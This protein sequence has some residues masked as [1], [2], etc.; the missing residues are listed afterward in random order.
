MALL[1]LLFAD[2]A[3]VATGI[4]APNT[5]IVHGTPV[6]YFGGNAARRGDANIAMLAEIWAPGPECG[7]I[8]ESFSRPQK[9]V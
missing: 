1:A 7:G 8:F 4:T 2:A 3:T 6:C 9:E 5:S